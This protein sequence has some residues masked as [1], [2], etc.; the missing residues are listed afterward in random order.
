MT[1]NDKLDARAAVAKAVRDGAMVRPDVCSECEAACLPQGHHEDYLKPLRVEWL[2]R[3]CHMGRHREQRTKP[4]VS[5]RMGKAILFR[6]D[7]DVDEKLEA[8]RK[9]M[10]LD[11]VSYTRMVVTERLNSDARMSA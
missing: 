1:E 9:A 2:C 8:A 4:P 6:L 7:A 10:G 3:K 11:R 5:S